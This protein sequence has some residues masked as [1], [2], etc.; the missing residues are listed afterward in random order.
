MK[1]TEEQLSAFGTPFKLPNPAFTKAE[2]LISCM[3]IS[4][5]GK[6]KGI[7]YIEN[8][9][10]V[11]TGAASWP[12]TEGWD[13]LYAQRVSR[14]EQYTGIEPLDRWD[15]HTEVQRGLRE[16]GYYG[17]KVLIDTRTYVFEEK[18]LTLLRG[19]EGSQIALF[20]L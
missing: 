7:V 20:E 13:Q 16:R 5:K 3:E 19:V 4:E 1:P 2:R 18:C 14:I 12:G 8:E 11:I 6:A 17:Q 15:H 9:P 10:Y